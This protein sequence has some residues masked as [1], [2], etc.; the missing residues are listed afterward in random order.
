MRESGGIVAFFIISLGL[1][2]VWD[3]IGQKQPNTVSELYPFDG[4]ARFLYFVGIPYITL[5]LGLLTWE[6]L[7]LTGLSSFDLIDWKA[8]I[9]L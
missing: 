1:P 4:L 3:R 7:G 8:N 2:I 9:F 5:L 6:N